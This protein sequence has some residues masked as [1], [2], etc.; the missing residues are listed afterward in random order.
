VIEGLALATG[1]AVLSAL[2]FHAQA[3]LRVARRLARALDEN[4]RSVAEPRALLLRGWPEWLAGAL[5]GLAGLASGLPW[6][7]AL[8]AGLVITAG[9][10]F[11]TGIVASRRRL[12]LEESLAA[13]LALAV[14]GLRAGASP[15]DAL[16]R[17]VREAGGPVKPLLERLVARLR[18]GES[19][20]QVL[21][22]LEAQE[23]RSPSL[24]LLGL[25]LGAQWA[26]GASLGPALN[27]VARAVRDRADLLRRIDTQSAP[28]RAS[29]GALLGVT[30][31]VAF[32]SWRQDPAGVAAFAAAPPGSVLVAA[33]L[34]L[35]ALALRWMRR[36][37]AIEV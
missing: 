11:V 36:L 13:L 28:A 22:G 16:D 4:A 19:A 10:G 27:G 18:L 33:A 37:L 35:Q 9:A 5:V 12:Q 7:V 8:G 31:L 23:S 34:C 20:A 3:R 1:G 26:A 25:A 30:T 15:L 17:A 2:A 24:R 29:V 21:S 6:P 14:A 32:L